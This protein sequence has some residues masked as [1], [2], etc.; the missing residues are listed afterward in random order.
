MMIDYAFISKDGGRERNEDFINIEER[1]SG[2]LFALADGLGG[3]GKG[4]V[5]SETVVTECCRVFASSKAECPEILEEAFNS[6][7]EVLLAKQKEAHAEDEMKTTLVLLALE[8][9]KAFW[10]HIG[11]SRLYRFERGKYVFRTL[12][13][14]VPQFL[15][16]T[17][18][19]P[20]KK[21]RFHEDRNRLL[22][23]V[24]IE[25]ETPRYEMCKEAHELKGEEAFLLCTDGFWE[26][27]TEREMEKC[28]KKAGNVREWLELMQ[29]KVLKNAA[30]KKM[31]NYSAI[32]VWAA[33]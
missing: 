6:A 18:E 14:S 8:K 17:G 9:G 13:H 25:W 20:E 28:Y 32:A 12:D 3:H 30:G 16:L 26:F 33:K 7:Q 21:I 5:A 11:D 23:V 24:G 19:I 31:D 2:K 15:V 27:I 1:E 22:R 4:E 10:G 29:A